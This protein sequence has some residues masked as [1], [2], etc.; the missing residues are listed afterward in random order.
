MASAATPMKGFA[1]ADEIR[2]DKTVRAALNVSPN[3]IAVGGNDFLE[4]WTMIG[5]GRMVKSEVCKA[6]LRGD[7]TDIAVHAASGDGA[8]ETVWTSF[9]DG[10]IAAYR[11]GYRVRYFLAH[12]GGATSICIARNGSDSG[13]GALV[14]SGGFDFTVKAWPAN[15]SKENEDMEIPGLELGC[16]DAV[17]N[18]VAIASFGATVPTVILSGCTNGNLYLSPSKVVKTAA[19]TAPERTKSRE[20]GASG[21]KASSSIECICV[22]HVGA[23][24]QAWTG[25]ADG[26][27]IAYR[28]APSG[29][30]QSAGG[31]GGDHDV[32]PTS[33]T[34][35]SFPDAHKSCVS[36]I[37]VAPDHAINPAKVSVWTGSATARLRRGRRPASGSRN[38]TTSTSRAAS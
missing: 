19:N 22:I 5:G 25:R 12:A 2:A 20:V 33:E 11:N 34:F 26:S 31:G 37:A 6:G 9:A 1:I 27:L 18:A 14:V 3:A 21:Q 30:S 15:L 38:S 36:C 24:I 32:L 4:M 13:S 23:S 28:I 29:E 8:E 7:V 35:V 16:H 10:H 17:V